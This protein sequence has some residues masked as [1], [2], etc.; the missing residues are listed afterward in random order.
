M[1]PCL[2]YHWKNWWIFANLTFFDTIFHKL[3][4]WWIVVDRFFPLKSARKIWRNPIPT[5]RAKFWRTCQSQPFVPHGILTKVRVW[6]GFGVDVAEI[7]WYCKLRR[8]LLLKVIMVVQ[9]TMSYNIQ[10]AAERPWTWVQLLLLVEM[11]THLK[12][13]TRITGLSNWVA[14]LR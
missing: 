8:D 14:T 6:M 4:I 13:A 10:D 3:D 11:I 12:L 7:Y 2:S 1:L 9:A 5:Q